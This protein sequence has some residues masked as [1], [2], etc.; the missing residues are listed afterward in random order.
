MKNNP[1]IGRDYIG[2]GVGALLVACVLGTAASLLGDRWWRRVLIAL[3][4]P[5]SLAL[6]GAGSVPAWATSQPALPEPAGR[7]GRWPWFAACCS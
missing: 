5:L 7:C 2:V 6:S 4:F 3:G 1:Q